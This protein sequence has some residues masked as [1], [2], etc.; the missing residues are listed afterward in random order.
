[1]FV[2]RNAS[3]SSWVGHKDYAHR[4]GVAIAFLR[5]NREGLPY[6]DE[7]EVMNR[8]E[9]SLCAVFEKNQ[10]AV[11]VLAITT[12]GMREF[13]FYSRDPSLVNSI[14]E[15]SPEFPDY[16]LTHYA[17]EDREWTWFHEFS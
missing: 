7:G 6:P 4:I 11:Q 12:K 5:P 9:D 16:E 2:R 17:T 13:V 8:I 10:G 1:M 14:A 3:V 15:V